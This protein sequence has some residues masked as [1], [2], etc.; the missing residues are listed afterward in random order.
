M[1]VRIYLLIVIRSIAFSALLPM[2]RMAAPCR[3]I[4]SSSVRDPPPSRP[5]NEPF[6]AAPLPQ[7]IRPP[8]HV[9]ATR[10]APS[11]SPY[12]PN[13]H[14]ITSEERQRYHACFGQV[15]P[16]GAA[17]SKA[18]TWDYL[19]RS[20]LAAPTLTSVCYLADVNKDG[21]FDEGEF[22][23]AVHLAVLAR[24]G[25]ALPAVLSDELVAYAQRV[26]AANTAPVRSFSHTLSDVSSSEELMSPPAPLSS[27]SR[28]VP[29]KYA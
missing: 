26:A 16:S 9:P 22:H 5:S 4:R 11:V 25:A 8:S 21:Y 14:M 23:V 18:A 3:T 29:I 7:F 17:I 20:N 19:Q 2:S 10:P 13:S 27:T 15:S 12:T 24:S 6:S 28:P 1:A